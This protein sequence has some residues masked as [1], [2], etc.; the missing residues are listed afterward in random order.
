MKSAMISYDLVMDDEMEFIEGTFR[1]PGADWQVI[2]TLRQDV[3]EPAVKQVRWDSGV[4]G[5]NLIV[6][7][8][9]QLNAS[10]VEAAL[11]E[12]FGVDRWVVV[13]G[14]DSMVLR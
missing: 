4:T 12:H 10:V 7:L 9:M 1:L 3:L 11:G 8:S 14:P 5:V 6:P 2:V 13:Q